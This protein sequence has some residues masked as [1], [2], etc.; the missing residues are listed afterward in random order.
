MSRAVRVEPFIPK[1]AETDL[2]PRS[3]TVTPQWWTMR[4]LGE[5]LGLS[6]ETIRKRISRGDI[7]A[8][9]FG[10]SVRISEAEAVRLEAEGW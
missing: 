7:K 9:K 10:R 4:Q 5:R 3:R 2:A 8:Q 1:P 6:E